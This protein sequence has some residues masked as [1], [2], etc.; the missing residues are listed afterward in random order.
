MMTIQRALTCF[1]PS[2]EQQHWPE[3]LEPAE[4]FLGGGLVFS[5]EIVG[6][7]SSFVSASFD[8]KMTQCPPSAPT[9]A[10]ERVIKVKM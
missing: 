10:C 2:L 1:L 8:D 7:Y 6:V 9:V 4:F 5:G 3:V